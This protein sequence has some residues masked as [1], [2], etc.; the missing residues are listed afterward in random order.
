MTDDMHDLAAAYALDALDTAERE[1]FERHLSDCDACQADVASFQQIAANLGAAEEVAPPEALKAR[2]MADL[3]PGRAPPLPKKAS[4][5]QR[6]FVPVVAVLAAVVLALAGVVA[7]TRATG[8]RASEILAAPD[9][10]L[11]ILEGPSVAR[12]VYSIA[13]DAGVLAMSGVED[14]PGD[15]TYQ[16]WLIG[17]EGPVP[18]GTFRS[19][20]GSVGFLV[21]GD[22]GAATAAGITIEPV[23][24]SPQPTTEILYLGELS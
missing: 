4:W 11:A 23:G 1:R 2:V 24:G 16:L 5:R 19:D 15:A 13:Q 17:E 6:A 9:A 18:A 3:D 7:A 20:D 14:L 10:Q 12:L 22:F 8:D 21:E